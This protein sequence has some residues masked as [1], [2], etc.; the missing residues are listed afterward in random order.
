M[1]FFMILADSEGV[2]GFG[3]FS[4]VSAFFLV[5]RRKNKIESAE[6]RWGNRPYFCRGKKN[7]THTRIK[8][9]GTCA[10]AK[11]YDDYMKK[12]IES[13][14]RVYKKSKKSI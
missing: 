1:R 14:S 12:F 3:E 4:K 7:F 13:L 5:R 11:G 9:G 8:R 6:G 2:R 10:L